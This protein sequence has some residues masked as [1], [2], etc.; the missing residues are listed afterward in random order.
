MV[1]V[2]IRATLSIA[3]IASFISKCGHSKKDNGVKGGPGPHLEDWI[4]Q[5]TR[6]FKGPQ[7]KVDDDGMV[8]F[9]GSCYFAVEAWSGNHHEG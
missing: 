5:P 1:L 9:V 2:M 3:A 8:K 4:L 6:L 7:D